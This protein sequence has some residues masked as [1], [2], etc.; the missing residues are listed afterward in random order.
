MRLCKRLTKLH[1]HL[2]HRTSCVFFILYYIEQAHLSFFQHSSFIVHT[3]P[4][5][6]SLA[7]TTPLVDLNE[8]PPIEYVRCQTPIMASPIETSQLLSLPCRTPLKLKFDIWQCNWSTFKMFSNLVLT[9]EQFIYFAA[10]LWS[11]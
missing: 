9:I 4:L 6:P 7:C 3:N 10:F 11:K 8:T 5:A 1:L 2:V